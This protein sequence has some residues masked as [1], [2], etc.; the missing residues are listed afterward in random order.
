MS[1]Y[2]K[3]SEFSCKCGCKSPTPSN[4]LLA[5]LT[6]IRVYYNSPVIITS[7]YRCP[8]H[9]AKV[10]GAKKS[11]HLTN[12]AADFIVVG[13]DSKEVYTFLNKL[14]PNKYG[15]AYKDSSFTHIDT[16]PNPR[17]WTY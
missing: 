6:L 1:T 9:N 10:G 14:F 13:I 2:F 8:T 7:G 15:L 3:D 11:K 16:D 17:R 5:L 12:T 4:E